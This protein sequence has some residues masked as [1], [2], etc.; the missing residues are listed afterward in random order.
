MA[1]SVSDFIAGRILANVYRNFS[2]ISMEMHGIHVLNRNILMIS[3]HFFD[4]FG[5]LLGE[6]V[7]RIV[8]KI[9]K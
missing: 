2:I 7:W 1:E 4:D 5:T 6:S 9:K 8:L 3:V